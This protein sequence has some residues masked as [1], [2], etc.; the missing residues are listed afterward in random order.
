[1]FETQRVSICTGHTV[2]CDFEDKITAQDDFVNVMDRSYRLTSDRPCFLFSLNITYVTPKTIQF[3]YPQKIVLGSK[4]PRKILFYFEN[5]S[6]ADQ[7]RCQSV[8]PTQNTVL[9]LSI[10][11]LCKIQRHVASPDDI[12]FSIRSLHSKHLDRAHAVASNLFTMLFCIP[13]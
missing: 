6:T 5:I 2:V 10:Q 3:H 1:M 12:I 8:S 11:T 7:V 4:C 13:P 9:P